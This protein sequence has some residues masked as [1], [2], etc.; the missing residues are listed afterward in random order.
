MSRSRPTL[1]FAIGGLLLLLAL[2]LLTHRPPPPAPQ[3][4]ALSVSSG[5]PPPPD[6]HTLALPPSSDLLPPPTDNLPPAEV[7]AA[8]SAKLSTHLAHPIVRPH[9]AI[10]IFKNAEGYHRFLARANGSGV[11]V[12]GR[13][14][15]LNIV[16]VRIRAYDTFAAQLVARAADY[17]GVSA[18]PFVEFPPLPQARVGSPQIP[19]GNTLLSVLGVPAGTDTSSWGRGVTI[20]ILDGGALPDPTFG[21]RLRYMDIGLGYAGTGVSGRHGTAVA[22]LAAGSAPDAPGVAPA[23]EIISIRISNTDDKSDIF[24]ITQAIVASVD[25]G[26]NIINLSLGGNATSS[27]INRAIAYA[28]Q[29]GAVIVASAGNNGAGRLKWPAADPHVVSVGATDAA[30]HQAFFSNSGERLVLTAPGVSLA[31][32]DLDGRRS[33]FSGTSA[34]APVVAGALAVVISQTPGLTAAQAVEILKTHSSDGGAPGP[35]PDYG[36]GTVDLGWALDRA[37]PAR[38]DT[39]VSAH[40]YNAET[41]SLEIVLQNRGTLPATALT[42]TIDLNG[43]P[44]THTIPLIE[45]GRS[46]AVSLPVDAALAA[47]PIALRTRLYNS[48]GTTDVA[49]AN[50]TRATL[51]DLAGR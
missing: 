3:P 31:A 13:I 11:I 21:A 17:G 16:R 8:L 33:L 32:A 35:D 28:S 25:A 15:P 18:N 10:L 19:V 38:V 36:H 7:V 22:G 9:E 50:N 41:A 37:N 30:G 12:A 49:P 29:H 4:V 40:H 6:S 44:S 46:L 48:E 1:F 45:P 34:S 47:A 51:L 42:L 2:F 39:A 14:D 5:S 24:T 43:R 23:A 27:A 20:A 26:A